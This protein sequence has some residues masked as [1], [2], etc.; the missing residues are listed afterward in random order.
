M[1]KLFIFLTALGLYTS[2]ISASIFTEPLVWSKWDSV[3]LMLCEA[4]L[5]SQ[6]SIFNM[7]TALNILSGTAPHKPEA[8]WSEEIILFRATSRP[9]YQLSELANI[10]L[11]NLRGQAHYLETRAKYLGE[12]K[13]LYIKAIKLK[14]NLAL[15]SDYYHCGQGNCEFRLTCQM[16]P[17]T[18]P[19]SSISSTYTRVGIK[20]GTENIQ[21]SRCSR[22]HV[23]P[24]DI[25]LQAEEAKGK[26]T[27]CVNNN[28]QKQ[29]DCYYGFT[30]E[31]NGLSYKILGQSE[32]KKVDWEESMEEQLLQISSEIN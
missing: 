22:S 9:L 6:E 27:A 28:K 5:Q 18:T 3:N 26:F 30:K 13:E 17:C 7:E 1:R 8:A 2:E 32:S 19:L 14:V 31:G 20:P 16:G 29:L 24:E 4:N 11:G 23:C 15:I 10:N 21:L 12:E 25:C